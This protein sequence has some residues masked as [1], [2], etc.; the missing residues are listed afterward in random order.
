MTTDLLEKFNSIKANAAAASTPTPT[1][2]AVRGGNVKPNRYGGKCEKCRS[3][4][5]PGAGSFRKGDTAWIVF[6]VECPET[7]PA[8][9]A[10][11]VEQSGALKH[12]TYTVEGD[13]GHASFR[14]SHQA[15][16][17]NFAPGKDIIGVM[18]GSDN[19]RYTSI[20]FVVEGRV[21]LFRKNVGVNHWW[22]NYLTELTA[23]PEAVLEA[24]NC[25]RCNRLLTTPES[26]A[27][28]IGPVCATLEG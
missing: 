11:A 9:K 14:I 3:W 2:P 10:P 16:D 4:V 18:L 27:D 20:G 26:I 1:A 24:L 5:E 6:H 19:E 8:A 21:R 15:D 13:E 22:D 12:G 25:R 7:V 23:D 17:A 28:G